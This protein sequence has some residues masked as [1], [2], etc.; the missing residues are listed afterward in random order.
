MQDLHLM[1]FAVYSFLSLETKF[2]FKFVT[3]FKLS[4]WFILGKSY[5]SVY[6]LLYVL[7]IETN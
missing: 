6:V 5:R 3:D 1:N 4:V 2:L 7:K